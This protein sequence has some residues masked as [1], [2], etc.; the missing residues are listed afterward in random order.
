MRVFTTVENLK[1]Y[2]KDASKISSTIGF[3][4]TMGAL[5]DGHISLVNKCL[6]ENDIVIVSVFVNPTQ[7]NNAKDLDNY[8]RTLEV[9]IELLKK[10][11]KNII[12]FAPTAK[13]LYKGQPESI[14]YDFG[15]LEN[16]MEGKFRPGHFDGVGTV[17]K[18]LFE[19]VTPTKAYFGEKDFQQLQIVRKLVKLEKFPI[20]IVGCEIFREAH[21]LA[22]SSRN[23]RL[24]KQQR[25]EAKIIYETLLNVK[26][27]FGTKSVTELNEMV[28]QV[29]EDQELFE[30]EYFEIANLK[31]LETATYIKSHEKYRAFIA[32]F[33]DD[34]RLIDNIALN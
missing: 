17:L 5:H 4:P 31:N 8:P 29:F 28:S 14:N 3:V 21:G 22:Y 25:Q 24:T 33:A 12:V 15:G 2:I 6:N 30:L 1:T 10:S 19:A 23:E 18:F 9:D 26:N 27:Q 20:E 7:F 32:V 11:S 13:N 16:E 34:V